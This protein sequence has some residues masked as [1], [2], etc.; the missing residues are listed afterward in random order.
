M[1]DS[2][3][4]FELRGELGR[5]AMAVVW[6]A[7][8]PG[9]E[10]EVAIKE[11]VIPQGTPSEVASELA[12]RFVREG[13]TVA[14]LNHP[15]IV[16]VFDSG[17]YGGRPGMIMELIEGVTLAEL[18]RA[19]YRL[20]TEAAL[21]VEFQLLDALGYAHQRGVVHRDVK[22]DNIFVTTDGHIKLADFGIARLADQTRYTLEGTVMGTPGY[23]AP[24][25]VRGLPADERADVFSAGAILYEMLTGSNPFGA[26]E[27]IDSTSVMYR[28]VHEDP[29]L[30]DG[31]SSSLPMCAALIAMNKLPSARFQSADEMSSAL[32][33][34]STIRTPCS[35]AK[36]R[37]IPVWVMAAG[38]ALLAVALAL[39]W[40]GSRPGT[41]ET[42]AVPSQAQSTSD[43][44]S[45]PATSDRPS[46]ADP[47]ADATELLR[48]W[49]DFLNSGETGLAY[50]LMTERFR[51]K[52]SQQEF[53]SDMSG[54][55]GWTFEE[56]NVTSSEGNVVRGVVGLTDGSQVIP[57]GF[58]AVYERGELLIDELVAIAM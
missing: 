18:L 48:Q 35:N 31:S 11:P 14:K 38:V 33:A 2:F 12:S 20:E 42:G 17:I 28:I 30:P 23:M 9:L 22:P 46:S 57:E 13:K 45:A 4:P 43:S 16:T 58:K 37:R 54:M 6:R 8:D 34:K 24:E 10:R 3:G 29:V 49:A 39:A 21:S 44:A 40:S 52:T 15:C 56:I 55:R 7:W 25:Q 27:G 26:G 51:A 47:E 32:T 41:I 36:S 50:L 19:E 1:Q 5:G 53:D